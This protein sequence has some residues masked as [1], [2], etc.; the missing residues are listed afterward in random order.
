MVDLTN[1][2]KKDDI[3]FEAI[4]SIPLQKALDCF[5]KNGTPKTGMVMIQFMAKGNFLKTA[6]FD[7]CEVGN[8]YGVNIIFRSLIEH[9]LKAQYIFMKWSEN[10]NDLTAEHYMQWYEASETYDFMKA[11]EASLKIFD[12]K[13]KHFRP[14]NDLFDQNPSYKAKSIREIKDISSQF[15]Y[16]NILKY[17][18]DKIFKDSDL[19]ELGHL[20]K[21]I[22]TYA[23]LSGYVHGGPTADKDMQKYSN[24]E[25]RDKALLNI[26]NLAV[27]E[28]GSTAAFLVLG[29]T[30]FDRSFGDLFVKISAAIKE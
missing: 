10:K 29:L 2:Y 4:A 5:K 3:L 19:K 24:E 25:E 22:P 11:V 9:T 26:A 1:V 21:I 16:R 17:I 13:N 8:I 20:K 14:D 23:E 15:K 27:K 7:L 18:N 12:P 30:F 28:A 6:I